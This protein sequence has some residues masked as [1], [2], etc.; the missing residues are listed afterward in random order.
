MDHLDKIKYPD[1]C[2]RIVGIL[3]KQG[4]VDQ[5]SPEVRAMR[6]ENLNTF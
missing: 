5:V 1:S 6:D 3:G 4:W 2:L